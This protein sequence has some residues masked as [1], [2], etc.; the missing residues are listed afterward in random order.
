M[1]SLKPR[2]FV[3]LSF[4]MQALRW[5]T[6]VSPAFFSS[7][8]SLFVYLEM[9]LFPSTS[10]PLSLCMEST[11]YVLSFQMVFFYLVTT[12]WIFYISLCENSINQSIKIPIVGVGKGGAYLL[13]HGDLPR[14]HSFGTTLRFTGPVPADSRQLLLLLLLLIHT[15]SVLSLQLKKIR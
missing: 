1:L 6:R 13:V 8:F 7:F 11:S 2:P 12:G 5:P 4:D 14:Q 15:F 10:F 3:Q 9:S